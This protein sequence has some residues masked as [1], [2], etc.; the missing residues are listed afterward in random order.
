[1]KK[2]SKDLADALK[3]NLSRVD[4]IFEQAYMIAYGL[5][6]II[7]DFNFKPTNWKDFKPFYGRL[8]IYTNSVGE[9][10]VYDDKLGKVY[11]I[12]HL[13]I[14]SALCFIHRLVELLNLGHL[15]CVD[16]LYISPPPLE[17]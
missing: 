13:D 14:I 7:S 11:S 5:I 12:T 8:Y 3:D 16:Y 17:F 9:L 4:E 15:D 6:D 10:R 1:M 2:L